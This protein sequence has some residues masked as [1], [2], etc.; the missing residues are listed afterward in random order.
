MN[1]VFKEDIAPAVDRT[2]SGIDALKSRNLMTVLHE[3]F[4]GKWNIG[5]GITP[6]NQSLRQDNGNIPYDVEPRS[7]AER[8]VIQ[9]THKEA[10]LDVQSE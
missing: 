10:Q 8:H 9:V 2:A 1:E 5:P 6:S 7:E 3:P 4:A